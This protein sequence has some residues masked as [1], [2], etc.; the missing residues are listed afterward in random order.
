MRFL[1]YNQHD[2][3]CIL[4]MHALVMTCTFHGIVN[5]M[6]SNRTPIIWGF[7]LSLAVKHNQTH[8]KV[9]PIE[10]NQTYK[11]EQNWTFGNWTIKQLN[12]IEQWPISVGLVGVQKLN[13]QQCL[14]LIVF[15]R[16]NQSKSIE[17]LVF[18]SL[19]S[20]VFFP[21]CSIDYARAFW[22]TCTSVEDKPF[23][24]PL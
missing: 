21:I 16:R 23:W 10:K 7:W 5:L 13:S 4:N 22:H 19:S 9:L 8:S 11:S 15:V 2:S 24:N 14:S 6:F 17:W 18:E 12:K 3:L 20:S 1:Y